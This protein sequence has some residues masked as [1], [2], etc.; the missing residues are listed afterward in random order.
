MVRKHIKL[1]FPHIQ[2]HSIW[3]LLGE[4]IIKIQKVAQKS[5]THAEFSSRDLPWR[6]LH[7]STLNYFLFM[8]IPI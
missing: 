3:R 5:N 4:A 2:L 1:A 6:P 7:I 8:F